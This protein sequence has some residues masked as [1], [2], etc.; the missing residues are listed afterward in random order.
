MVSHFI[1]WARPLLCDTQG[2]KEFGL[3]MRV[4]ECQSTKENIEKF[5]VVIEIPYL[6][7]ECWQ[8]DQDALKLKGI[9]ADVTQM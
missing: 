4:G 5:K 2:F 8:V 1:V 6:M 7:E 9:F 3:P